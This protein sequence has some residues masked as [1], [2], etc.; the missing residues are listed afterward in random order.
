MPNTAAHPVHAQALESDWQLDVSWPVF[1]GHFPGAPVLPGA[2]LID[3]A[4][5]TVCRIDGQAWHC[6]QAKFP[7][8][9]APGDTLRLRLTPSASGRSFVVSRAR[10]GVVL[11]N[12][13]LV[14]HALA[15]S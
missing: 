11:A 6:T 9:A 15:A 3:W 5:Q 2:V 14:A 12:G 4:V 10:D 13:T 8:A 1:A 7:N